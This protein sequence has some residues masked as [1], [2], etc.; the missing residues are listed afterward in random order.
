[1]TAPPAPPAQPRPAR[2]HRQSRSPLPS[3]PE[4]VG[5]LKDTKDPNPTATTPSVPGL[6]Q[7]C[8]P[9]ELAAPHPRLPHPAHLVRPHGRAAPWGL[10]SRPSSGTSRHWA[11][12][13]G[14]RG[15][16]SLGQTPRLGV[17]SDGQ[18]VLWQ[19]VSTGGEEP[20]TRAEPC[21]VSGSH[22]GSSRK[23]VSCCGQNCLERCPAMDGPE[24]VGFL[25]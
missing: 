12:W 3:G 16:Y 11:V 17:Q 6:G 24:T 5:P 2:P 8:S 21:P 7:S 25:W 14:R 22:A 20:S 1:M 4:V 23:R 9:G 19:E 15:C 10:W 18:V 13:R